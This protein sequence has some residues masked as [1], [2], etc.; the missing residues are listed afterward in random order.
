MAWRKP[1]TCALGSLDE[2]WAHA[3]TPPK[4]L[5]KLPRSAVGIPFLQGGEDVK[6]GEHDLRV[7]ISHGKKMKRA[8]EEHHK[9]V[10]WLAFEEEGHGLERVYNQKVFLETLLAF[11]DKHIGAAGKKPAAASAK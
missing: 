2:A 3:P 1:S 8:L 5:R 7:P 9:S 10:E 11:L 4:R 6:H